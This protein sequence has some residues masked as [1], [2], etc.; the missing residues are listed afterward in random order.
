MLALDPILI[1]ETAG[2]R[3]V[4]DRPTEID[5]D[6]DN[7]IAPPSNDLRVAKTM[8]V[9]VL[10]LVG[11]EDLV[12]FRDEVDE[13]E[14]LDPLAVRPAAGEIRR[15]IKSVVDRAGKMEILCQQLFDCRAVLRDIGFVASTRD[16]DPGICCHHA[17]LSL[18]D[19]VSFHF[20]DD[21]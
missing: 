8:T 18:I 17:L 3:F 14:A 15:A 13:V 9:G 19:F 6:L 21:P 16:R 4:R 1:D 12:I 7:L 11:D 20:Y 2:W 5:L 10:P